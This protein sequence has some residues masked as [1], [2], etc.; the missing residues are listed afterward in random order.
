MGNPYIGNAATFLVHTIF[1]IYILIVML[2]FMFQLC[3]ADFYNPVSQVI[4]KL[5]NPPLLPLRRL[6]PGVFGLDSAALVLVGGLKAIELWLV[7]SL[8]GA[9]PNI[10]GVAVLTIAELL[11]LVVNIFLFS[12]IMQVVISWINPGTYNPAL[13]L[14][15]SLTEP[16]LRPIR[17]FMP[18][19]AGLDFS[20]LVAM[21]ALALANMLI[22]T[23]IRDQ[24]S[25]LM[26]Q[27]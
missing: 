4:V 13:S 11:A 1:G 10:A 27:L 21:V 5:T 8:G 20:P 26:M 16:V 19:A 23:P 14:L 17:R 15:H 25:L 7:I 18:P 12:I 24:G 22:V 9:S 6:V 2:R 3:R